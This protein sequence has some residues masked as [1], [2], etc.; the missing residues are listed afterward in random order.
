[1]INSAE[2][3]GDLMRDC[4]FGVTASSCATYVSMDAINYIDEHQW[5]PM[6]IIGLVGLVIQAV[7][8]FLNH[9]AKKNPP[10]RRKHD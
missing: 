7:G 9:R 8:V 1:M 3:V 2:K 4:G 5:I 10:E 6:F